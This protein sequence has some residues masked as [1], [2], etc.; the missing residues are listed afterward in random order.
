MKKFKL[1]TH[2]SKETKEYLESIVKML[3]EGEQLSE[4][5]YPQL[6]LLAWNYEVFK[7]AEKQLLTGGLTITNQQGNIVA[8]PLIKIMNDAQTKVLQISKGFGLSCLDRKKLNSDVQEEDNSLLNEFLNDE[9][10]C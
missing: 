6:L 9:E 3:L 5:D 4:V 8:N 10:Q 2:Y 7:D 1:P